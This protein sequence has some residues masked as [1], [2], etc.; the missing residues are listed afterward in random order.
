VPILL[1]VLAGFFLGVAFAWMARVELGKNDAPVI[2]T[3]PFYVVVGFATF[4]YAPI[5]AYFVAFH[6]D[7]TYGYVIAWHRVPS[8]IDL[9]L[10]LV[11]G[12]SV[13]L[14]MA[15]SA[16]A[17]RTRRLHI[18]AWLGIV[19]AATFSIAL[20]L[21]AG[22]LAVSATYAQYH[23]GFGVSAISSSALGRGVLLMAF[24]LALG[25]AWTVRALA[26]GA[27]EAEE[28]AKDRDKRRPRDL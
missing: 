14:G 18:V 13:L 16:H 26:Q 23:G 24:V 7:W 20:A 5:L 19:P 11:S 10:V 15:A 28:R 3:R 21:G 4:V 1:A 17:S 6:G 9:A 2:A 12:S 27:E 22:R 25:I 8:A